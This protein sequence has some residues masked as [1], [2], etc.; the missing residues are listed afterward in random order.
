M[1]LYVIPVH[2]ISC[3]CFNISFTKF[4]FHGAL[5]LYRL[6]GRNLYYY[7]V[8]EFVTRKTRSDCA[9]IRH[10]YCGFFTTMD[11]FIIS[12]QLSIVLQLEL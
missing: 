9:R 12:V 5:A 7:G 8:Y 1:Y 2:L 4:V 11:L 10:S 6:V 3:L